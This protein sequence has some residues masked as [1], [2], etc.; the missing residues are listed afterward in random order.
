M[1]DAG[2]ASSS[3]NSKKSNSS[4]SNKKRTLSDAGLDDTAESDSQSNGKRVVVFEAFKL[5]DV[6]CAEDLDAKLLLIQNKKLFECVQ[7]YRKAEVDWKSK[8]DQ[9]ETNKASVD[10][11]WSMIDLY[12]TQLDEN[13]RRLL[14]RFD[15]TTST[16][17]NNEAS[18]SLINDETTSNSNIT[19]TTNSSTNNER[20]GEEIRSYIHQLNTWL[21]E[22]LD[23][24]LKQ[25]LDF[26]TKAI[27]KLVRVFD[28]LTDKFQR[29]FTSINS[30]S[31][32]GESKSIPECSNEVSKAVS[33][34]NVDLERENDR[35]QRLNTSLQSRIHEIT[36]RCSDLNNQLVLQEEQ[37][38][39]RKS[40]LS[41]IEYELEKSRSKETKL[42]R[43]LA[44]VITKLERDRLKFQ[45]N[46]IKNDPDSNSNNS[47]NNT[48]IIAENKYADLQAEIEE[49]KELA[50]GRL[51]ELEKLMSDHETTK[52]EIEVLKNKL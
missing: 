15:A 42:E 22:D 35:I 20:Q 4:T 50:A 34:R 46:D 39:E 52:R 37:L 13:I 14:E 31:S 26:S 47:N 16:D 9:L 51:A 5:I 17:G 23:E 3:T 2:G 48:V 27:V 38:L 8:I 30:S 43:S 12:W 21:R 10:C 25:R 49:Y 45:A 29:L 19:N 7:N 6:Q 41:D 36:L 32:T 24:H 1:S 40:H 28:N 44:D 18:S 11:K 33:E